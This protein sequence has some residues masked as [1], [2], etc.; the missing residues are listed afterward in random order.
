MDPSTT[1]KYR[2]RSQ[3]TPSGRNTLVTDNDIFG[4]F[5][6][7]S[8]HA[9]LTTKQLVAFDPRYASTTRSRLT[10]LYHAE[11]KWLVRLSETLKLANFLTVDEMHR[12]RQRRR[13]PAE[14][15]RDY[16]LG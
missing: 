14:G 15:T 12:A 9:R 5:E 3:P 11:G 4:I 1:R 10:D 7:L 13:G 16:S 6:P 2:P 8:R